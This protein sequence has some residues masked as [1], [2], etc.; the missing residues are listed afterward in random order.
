[1]YII[2][3][4]FEYLKTENNS[5]YPPTGKWKNKWWYTHIKAIPRNE[6]L[7]HST[8]LLNLKLIM[9][10]GK[11]SDAFPAKKKKYKSINPYLLNSVYNDRNPI[12][13]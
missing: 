10:E 1:M 13:S 9:P 6:L 11:K 5:K 8:T 4:L 7:M 2:A 3:A 12:S